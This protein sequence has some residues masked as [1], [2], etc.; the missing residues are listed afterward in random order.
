MLR[1]SER[2][3]LRREFEQREER[4]IIDVVKP[5]EITAPDAIYT[6]PG[7]AV[8]KEFLPREVRPAIAPRRDVFRGDGRRYG[9][10]VNGKLGVRKIK[11]TKAQVST[12]AKNFIDI[13]FDWLN[14]ILSGT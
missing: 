7:G 10:P 9:L 1:I 8:S 13:F 3:G 6:S 4:P 2:R 5:T 14:K 12:P 11:D